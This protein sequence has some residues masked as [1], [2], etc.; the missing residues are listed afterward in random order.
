M[1]RLIFT[2]IFVSALSGCSLLFQDCEKLVRGSGS[3]MSDEYRQCKAKQGHQQY[4]YELGL[5]AYTA[6]DY[7]GAIKWLKQ[8]ATPRSGRTAIY[9]PAV[10]S[11]KYGTVMM[12]D[13]GQAAAGHPGALMLL[14]EIYDKGLG[15]DKNPKLVEKYRKKTQ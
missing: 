15:V 14:A 5:A 7:K 9:M 2:I 1:K 10:G 11:Q 13:T 8:A 6:K 12:M 3:Q 4:Q